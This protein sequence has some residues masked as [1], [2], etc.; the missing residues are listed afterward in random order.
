MP[1]HQVRP[2]TRIRLSA[3]DADD[4]GDFT[5]KSAAEGKLADDV[6]RL[7]RLQDKL[8]AEKRRALLVVLQAMD[9]GGKDG[10]IKHVMSG[11][12]PIGCKVVSFKQPSEEELDHDFLWRI[13]RRLPRRGN[14]GIFNRSHY[15]DV[16]V[17]RVHD[18]VPPSEWGARYPP[19]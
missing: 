7:A 16:L 12:N 19:P 17:V 15:E 10:T 18:L 5:D 3:I 13:Y 4:T 1:R 14:I 8:Y 6:K 2:G 9:T 11:V